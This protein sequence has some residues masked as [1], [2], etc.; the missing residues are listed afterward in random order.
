MG[1]KD[2]PRLYLDF[3][4]RDLTEQDSP[5]THVNAVSNAKR[6]LHFQVDILADALGFKHTGQKD[7]F[8][9]RLGFCEMWSGSPAYSYKLNRLRNTQEH[10]YYLPTR[11]EAEDFVDG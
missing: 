9:N 1:F 11:G 3:A 4:I 6:S 7:S 10:E 8:P 2:P 5:R